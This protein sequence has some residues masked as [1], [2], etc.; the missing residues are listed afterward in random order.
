MFGNIRTKYSNIQIIIGIQN[1][2]KSNTN[3][4]IWRKIFEYIRIFVRTLIVR[5]YRLLSLVHCWFCFR[6]YWTN[7][8]VELN[9][10]TFDAT[11]N[12]LNTLNLI[13]NIEFTLKLNKSTA[14]N[15]LVFISFMVMI[16]SFLFWTIFISKKIE[17]P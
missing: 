8:H 4:N 7:A 16:K 9:L 17:Q 3:I 13:Q 12:T 6:L 2:H 14:I 15:L 5:C 1:Y 11:N 10:A